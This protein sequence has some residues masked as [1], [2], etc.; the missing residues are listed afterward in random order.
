MDDDENKALLVEAERAFRQA[1]EL[2]PHDEFVAKRLA[3]VL[4][5]RGRSVDALRIYLA[6]ARENPDRSNV[7]EALWTI[8]TEVRSL[9]F[10][11]DSQQVAVLARKRIENLNIPGMVDVLCDVWEL[12]ASAKIKAEESLIR[13]VNTVTRA[14]E[15]TVAT[16]F[17]CG[18][19]DY[20]IPRALMQPYLDLLKRR[21]RWFV[22]DIDDTPIPVD[23]VQV[24]TLADEFSDSARKITEFIDRL[25][26]LTDT[27]DD[28]GVEDDGLHLDEILN[29]ARTAL[30]PLPSIHR[31]CG[32]ILRE[33]SRKLGPIERQLYAALEWATNAHDEMFDADMFDADSMSFETVERDVWAE[34]RLQA[35]LLARAAIANYEKAER[36]CIAAL[37]TLLPRRGCPE[38]T[39]GP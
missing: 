8:R 35:I 10:D 3:S 33:F 28:I 15:S 1:L 25:H 30:L 37:L 39:D 24:R 14:I 17:E 12:T 18:L 32:R 6:L 4:T 36:E 38:L 5:Q 20:D 23:S 26:K 31:T 7:T 16:I 22:L 27:A 29:Q 34:E 9:K 11:W 2:D 13:T 21:A 19:E